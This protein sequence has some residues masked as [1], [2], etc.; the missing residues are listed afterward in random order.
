MNL[1]A[2]LFPVLFIGMFILIAY[3]VSRTGWVRLVE[4]YKAVEGFQG[5]RV[6]FLISASVNSGNY[7]NMIILKYNYEGIYLKT[8]II[9]RA[10]HPPVLI[11]WSEIKEVRERKIFFTNM[12]E[13]VV[14]DPFVAII[15]LKASVY[16]RIEKPAKFNL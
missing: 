15:T 6:G 9:F 7:N 13:L 3:I 1:F 4:K 16:N 12:K 11:P 14:G 5:E 2:L 10:F 8:G